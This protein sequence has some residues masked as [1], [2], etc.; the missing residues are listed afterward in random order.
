MTVKELIEIL[1]KMNQSSE[2]T[3]WNCEWDCHDPINSVSEKQTQDGES[4]VS[5]S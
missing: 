5:F 2:V 4:V 1:S 3:I